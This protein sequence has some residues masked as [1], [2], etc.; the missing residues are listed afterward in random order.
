MTIPSIRRRLLTA[1]A[2]VAVASTFGCSASHKSSDTTGAS[3]AHSGAPG[4]VGAGAKPFCSVTNPT[5]LA[6]A[7]AADAITHE[8][9]EDLV[10]EAVAPDGASFAGIDGHGATS[11]TDLVLVADHG[12]QRTKIFTLTAAYPA[13]GSVS[14]DGRWVVFMARHSQD[15]G[16][17]WDLYAWDS[18]AGGAAHMIASY[19]GNTPNAPIGAQDVQEGKATWVQGLADGTQ[20]V[21]LYDLASGHDQVVHTGHIGKSLFAG[22]L[23]AWTQ[24]LKDGGPITLAAVS[25]AT[26]APATLPEPLASASTA[27]AAVASDGTTWAWTSADFQTLYAWHPGLAQAVVV[28]AAADGDSVDDPGVSGG[29]VT[30]TGSQATYAANLKTGSY[31][32]ITVQYGEALVNGAAIAVSYPVG[33]LKSPTMVYAGYVLGSADFSS[34]G[35]CTA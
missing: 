20:Q 3:V 14:Y 10:P 19:A 2:V 11:M 29:V 5:A 27:P 18:Q 32:Q 25:T 6:G 4:A 17:A 33:D 1:A 23:L 30:W 34:L 15:L 13:Y 21:H 16:G 26:G 35:E 9:G 7:E 12:R 22:G 28:R 24:A 8:P 31:T